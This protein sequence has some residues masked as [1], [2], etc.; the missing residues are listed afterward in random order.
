MHPKAVEL[1]AEVEDPVPMYPA[2][3]FLK[4]GAL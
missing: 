4:P 1:F 3:A 2:A